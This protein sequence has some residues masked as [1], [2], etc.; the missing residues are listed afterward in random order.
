MKIESGSGDRGWL[1]FL[2]SIGESP[3]S[4]YTYAVMKVV[5][6]Y[7]MIR[8]VEQGVAKMRSVNCWA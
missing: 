4:C 5:Q 3:S 1:D 6:L 8:N 7:D 2:L